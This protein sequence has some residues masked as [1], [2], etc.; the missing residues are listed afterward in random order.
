[1]DKVFEKQGIVFEGNA[2]KSKAFEIP[3][4]DQEDHSD[5]DPYG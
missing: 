3:D 4:E 5:Y 2:E 1:M